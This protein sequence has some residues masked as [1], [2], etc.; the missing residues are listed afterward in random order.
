VVG[1]D[2]GVSLTRSASGDAVLL[3]GV[4]APLQADTA[5]LGAATRRV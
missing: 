1:G 4:D 5:T 3:A 2:A